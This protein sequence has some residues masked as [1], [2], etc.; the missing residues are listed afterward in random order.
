MKKLILL[1]LLLPLTV[2][3]QDFKMGMNSS[4]NVGEEIELKFELF[5]PAGQTEMPATLL[6]FDLEYNNKLLEYVSHT[7]DPYNHL[8]GEQN[9]RHSWS[10]YKFS[11]DTNYSLN[12]LYQQYQW[13]ASGAAAAGV[14]PYPSNADFSVNRFT[15]QASE[16]INLNDAVLTMKF[17]ILDRQGTNYQNYNDVVNISWAKLI[18]N[19]DNTE[20]QLTSSNRGISL[21][22][23]GVGAGDITLTLSVPHNNKADYGYSIFEESQL[24]GQ[25]FNNDGVIDAYYP[26]PDEVPFESGNF[27]SEGI[28]SL[29]TLTLDANY[30]VHTHIIQTTSTA[31]DGSTVYGPEWLDDV[32]TVTDVYKIFQFSLDSD[33]NGGGGSWEYDIQN[34]LGEVTNDGKVDFS[35]SY[36]LLAHINGVT[37][38]ANVT[39]AENGAFSLSALM[40]KYGILGGDWHTF[41]PTESTTSFTIGHGLRGDVDFS[42]STVPTAV[43]AKVATA[44]TARTAMAVMAN[45]DVETHNLDIASQLVDGK[46]V[47]NI[48]LDSQG[49]VGTQ[50]KIKYDKNILTLDDI[51]YDTGSTMTNFGSVKEGIASFGSLD[52]EGDVS[53][54][55]GTPYQLIFTPNEAISNTAGLVSFK[56]IEGVKADGTKVKF[57]F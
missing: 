50:F 19:R 15:I 45:R 53:V 41:K 52:Y 10:G 55:T 13:W 38:S 49:L 51:K 37:T 48:N 44:A 17:K 4:G 16:D 26:A 27:N 39:T 25:D 31:Q 20:H 3:A 12:N 47:V 23:T 54:K 30:W 7:F 14:N 1:V 18:D 21:D 6:Q 32:V 11:P 9:S 46:V 40:D 8:T 56:I 2:F 42:H 33:I 28:S 35:D 24:E 36:E 57:Q 5:P 22:P 29:S 43:E 34:I